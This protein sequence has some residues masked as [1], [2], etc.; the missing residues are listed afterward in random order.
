MR[1]RL[2]HRAVKKFQHSRAA[3]KNEL[4]KI[5]ITQAGLLVP[6]DS[7]AMGPPRMPLVSKIVVDSNVE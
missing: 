4:W 1:S 5:S 7:Q 2:H 6:K 3:L